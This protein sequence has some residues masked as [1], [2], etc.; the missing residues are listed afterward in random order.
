MAMALHAPERHALPS[1][2]R[3]VDPIQ[4]CCNAEFF[5]I[6][7]ALFIGLRHAM[8]GRRD[9]VFDGWL[10]KQISGNLFDR[11]LVVGQ[12]AVQ[13]VDHPVAIF[14]NRSASIQTQASGIGVTNLV[15]PNARPTFAERKRPK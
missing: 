15:Q 14:P 6:G 10:R 2:P 13:R 9:A 7:T 4:D 3:R 1:L 5:I 12:I 8:R 11:E